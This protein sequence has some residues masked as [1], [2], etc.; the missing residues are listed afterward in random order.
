MIEHSDPNPD[1]TYEEQEVLKAR[2]YDRLKKM[3]FYSTTNTCLRSFMLD[4]FGEKSSNYCGNCSNCLTQFTEADVTIEAQK[5]LSCISR[6]KQRFGKKMICDILRGSRNE[7]ILRAGLDGQTTYGSMNGYKEEQVR[8]ILDHLE[9]E[10]YI[11]SRGAAYPTLALGEK[12]DAVLFD[13]ERVVMKRAKP[14]DVTAGKIKKAKNFENVDRGLFAALKAL[15]R[16]IA[17]EM[18]VPAYIVFSDATLAD[19]CK[20]RPTTLDE[21]LAVSGV[22]QAKLGLYGERFLRTLKSYYSISEKAKSDEPP[23]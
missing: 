18:N 8:E 6:T 2:A 15:R 16:M 4:Y 5:I 19:M 21:M 12:A 13:N 20:V 3:T 11:E 14:K 7:K 1:L 10:G 23:I 17:D 9:F 22:G